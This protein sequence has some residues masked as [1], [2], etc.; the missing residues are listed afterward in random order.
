M[1][2]FRIPINP[3]L[4]SFGIFLGVLMILAGVVLAILKVE[5]GGFYLPPTGYRKK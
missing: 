4:R 5:R 1:E 3:K 2:D